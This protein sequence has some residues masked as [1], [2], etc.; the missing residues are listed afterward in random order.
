MDKMSANRLLELVG[1][2]TALGLIENNNTTGP[3]GSSLDAHYCNGVD[4]LSMSLLCSGPQ[5]APLIDNPP[6]SLQCSEASY[7][8]GMHC[9]NNRQ[10]LPKRVYNAIRF[11]SNCTHM[12][13]R[14][15]ILVN[16][17]DLSLTSKH[18]LDGSY[19]AACRSEAG[20]SALPIADADADETT[21]TW[22]DLGTSVISFILLL[23]NWILP[24]IAPSWPWAYHEPSIRDLDP[25]T[26]PV[27]QK[28]AEVGHGMLND[29]YQGVCTQVSRALAS[30]VADMRS[31]SIGAL[32]EADERFT[33]G[34][35][36]LAMNATVA[37]LLSK[38]DDV[39]QQE[40]GAGSATGGSGSGRGSG[41][42]GL[43]MLCRFELHLLVAQLVDWT[44]QQLTL[45]P[46]P[47][48]NAADF[49]GSEIFT[50]DHEMSTA[51]WPDCRLCC[52][53][54]AEHDYADNGGRCN[55]CHP[56]S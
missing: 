3:L 29:T 6:F 38:G 53:A 45:P 27:S 54:W 26:S 24:S 15:F 9:E 5:C 51:A 31:G 52:A 23:L 10:C 1:T 20:E 4:G 48:C 36:A 32:R 2:L 12:D 56:V 30:L 11:T 17:T 16:R 43:D 7:A 14:E 42:G 21:W 50:L 33:L 8:D 35:G 49:E 13:I 55:C 19:P 22:T 37:G 18:I 47:G 34:Q 44:W 25:T 40:L 39:L 41:R 46:P 28:L